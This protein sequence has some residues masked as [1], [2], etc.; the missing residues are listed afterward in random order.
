MLLSIEE[1]IS[2][3]MYATEAIREA[4]TSDDQ[5]ALVQPY[6]KNV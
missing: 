6:T 2:R 1:R 3:R 4:V 5:S